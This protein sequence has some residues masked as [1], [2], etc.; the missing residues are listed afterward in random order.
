MMINDNNY[1]NSNKNNNNNNNNDNNNNII[2]FIQEW[3]ISMKRKM[4]FLTSIVIIIKYN[5]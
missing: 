5:M 2:I 4:L 3:P 1:N